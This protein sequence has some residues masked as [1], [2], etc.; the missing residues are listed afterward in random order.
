M[1]GKRVDFAG[2]TCHKP[3]LANQ[4]GQL[5]LKRQMCIR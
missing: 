5:E 4:N 1:F 2:H 3:I